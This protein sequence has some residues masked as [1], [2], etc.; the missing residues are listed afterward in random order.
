ML[1]L[2][3]GVLK[4]IFNYFKKYHEKSVNFIWIYSCFGWM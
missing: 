4:I 1:E 3:K 2:F